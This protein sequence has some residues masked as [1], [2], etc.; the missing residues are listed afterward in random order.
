MSWTQGVQL[1]TEMPANAVIFFSKYAPKGYKFECIV[2]DT[3]IPNIVYAHYY[4]KYKDIKIVK[5]RL[6]DKSGKKE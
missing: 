1:R 6:R 5:F 4:K 3:T 2:W